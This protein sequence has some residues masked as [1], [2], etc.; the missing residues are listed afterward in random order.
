[1]DG[2]A[3]LREARGEN[4]T[5]GLLCAEKNEAVAR[6]SVLNDVKRQNQTL[7]SSVFGPE[8]CGHG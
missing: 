7:F 4:A 3:M 5:I 1:M 8:S 6:Y 2:F